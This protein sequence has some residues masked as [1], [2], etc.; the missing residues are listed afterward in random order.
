MQITRKMW[1]DYAKKMSAIDT[2]AADLMRAW[3]E[4][5]GTEDRDALLKYANALIMHYGEASASLACEMYDSIASAEGV[6]VSPAEPVGIP[7]FGEVAKAVNGALKQS[8]N[9]VPSA[10]ARMTKM[11]GADTTLRNAERDGAQ[12]AWIASGE[13]CKFC[14]MLAAK[15]WQYMSKHALKNGHAEHIHGNCDCQYVI[16]FDKNTIVEGSKNSLSEV[17]ISATGQR[18]RQLVLYP[19]ENIVERKGVRY[20]TH[21]IKDSRY[22]I[23]VSE[24]TILKKQ[25]LENIEKAIDKVIGLLGI[26]GKTKLPKIYVLDDNE[27]EE[28]VF[29]GYNYIKNEMF[30]NNILGNKKETIIQ[31][32]LYGFAKP[33]MYYSTTLHEFL[34]W[35]DAVEYSNLYGK[36]TDRNAKQYLKY[37]QD[38]AKLKLNESEIGYHN[39]RDICRYAKDSYYVDDY[40]E[41]YTEYRVT[42]MG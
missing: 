25:G 33:Q 26:N 22:G 14:L 5:H 2:K 12:F 41:V 7:K 1:N 15:G 34:H 36:I 20:R 10:V 38:R 35:Q 24:N 16:R 31:Q 32:Q 21:L 28:G 13:T 37:L 29:A 42:L 40:D 23:S 4:A 6:M 39:V 27:L 30:L 8:E 3:I 18:N 9:V 19:Q 17:Y 11:M